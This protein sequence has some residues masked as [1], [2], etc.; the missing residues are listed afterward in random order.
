MHLPEATNEAVAPARALRC[1]PRGG[2][3]R[4]DY[5]NPAN[6]RLWTVKQ[7]LPANAVDAI[8]EA[9]NGAIY[10]VSGDRVGILR[11]KENKP[12][13]LPGHIGAT[14][15]RIV[16]VLVDGQGVVWVRSSSHFRR[17]SRPLGTDSARAVCAR[18][19]YPPTCS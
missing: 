9:G 2:L 1:L 10:F 11:T 16:A 14:D 3:L 8:Y 15:E 7:G 12:E 5:D 19:G 6:Y 4:F 17:A 18:T 13:I